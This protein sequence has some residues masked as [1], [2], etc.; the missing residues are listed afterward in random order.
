M[1]S[2]T[3]AAVDIHTGK[4]PHDTAGMVTATAVMVTALTEV[5]SGGVGKEVCGAGQEGRSMGEVWRATVRLVA[6]AMA[7]ATVVT[8]SRSGN[9]ECRGYVGWVRGWQERGGGGADV[10]EMAKSR[11]GPTA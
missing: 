3:C 6:V 7:R 5:G 4:W 2:G 11:H 8:V 1:V 10:M 9:G